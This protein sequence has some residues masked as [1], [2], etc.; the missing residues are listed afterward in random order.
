MNEP[1]ENSRPRSR[2]AFVVLHRVIALALGVSLALLVARVVNGW[3]A[4]AV[5]AAVVSALC[6]WAWWLMKRTRPGGGTWLNFLAAMVLAFR[7]ACTMEQLK[8][9]ALVSGIGWTIVG[10]ATLACV[11]HLNGPSSAATSFAARAIGIGNYLAWALLAIVATL[12]VVHRL[13]RGYRGSTADKLNTQMIFA[14][15]A[16]VLLSVGLHALG[17]GAVGL[18]IAVVALAGVTAPAWLYGLFML[19]VLTLRKPVRWN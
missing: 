7:G 8:W 2:V 1:A 16:G 19:H 4:V 18:L 15:I 13:V 12:L 9:Y 3:S 11:G 5:Y 6:A 10:T 14:C 17:W